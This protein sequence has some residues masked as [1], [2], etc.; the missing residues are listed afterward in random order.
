M[1]RTLYIKQV[2]L[3]R[4]ELEICMRFLK[5]CVLGDCPTWSKQKWCGTPRLF[6]LRSLVM[7]IF[8]RFLPGQ[9]HAQCVHVC[10]LFFCRLLLL[11]LRADFFCWEMLECLLECWMGQRCPAH[12]NPY[13]T[14]LNHQDRIS[15]ASLLAP[16]ECDHWQ[17]LHMLGW[18]RRLVLQVW[19][20]QGLLGYFCFCK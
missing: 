16:Q 9:W 1:C 19:Y 14:W 11:L 17:T 5:L 7:L 12:W 6:P 8:Y 2:K 4:V 18:C 15:V 3:L 13:Q 20:P 10:M